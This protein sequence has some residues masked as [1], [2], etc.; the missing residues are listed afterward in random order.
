VTCFSN[1]RNKTV[2][3]IKKTPKIG[4]SS[5]DVLGFRHSTIEC[6]GFGLLSKIMLLLSVLVPFWLLA[7]GRVG[8]SGGGGRWAQEA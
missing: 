5:I 6:A 2:E 4:Y 8:G 7:S 1:K 3:K